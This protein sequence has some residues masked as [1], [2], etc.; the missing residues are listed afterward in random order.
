MAS[1]TPTTNLGLRTMTDAD[2]VDAQDINYNSGIL[3]TKIGAVGSTSLQAQVDKVRLAHSLGGIASI[4]ALVNAI[5]SYIT[6]SNGANQISFYASASQD[7]WTVNATYSGFITGGST[8]WTAIV[9]DTVGN[10]I[11]VGTYN[12]GSTYNYTSTKELNAKIG[13]VTQAGALPNNADA[14][15]YTEP[16]TYYLYQ[17]FTYSNLPIG[18]GMFRITKP[19]SGATF[20]IQEAY[21]ANNAYYRTGSGGSWDDWR[22]LALNPTYSAIT[23]NNGITGNVTLMRMGKLRMLTGYVNPN[24]SGANVALATLDVGDRPP[25][26][27][28]GSFSGFGVTT[29]GEF[30]IYTNGVF[31]MAVK[32]TPTNTVKFNITYGVS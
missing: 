14:N 2:S 31:E 22:P 3:D 23:L 24:T 10:I 11:S 28:R 29:T 18:Y 8:N 5:Q 13:T 21:N 20:V 9:S 32:E 12:G 26:L 19:Y 17:S 16:A 30:N 25:V 1:G 6:T 4:S 27:I 15:S 7:Y